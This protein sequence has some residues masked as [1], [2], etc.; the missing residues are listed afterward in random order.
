[1]GNSIYESVVARLSVL[2]PLLSRTQVDI[3][4]ARIGTDP[5]HVTAVQMAQALNRFI[6]P[7]IQE[8][9]HANANLDASNVAQLITD[10]ERRL[11]KISPNLSIITG[12][13]YAGAGGFKDL[14]DRIVPQISDFDRND[15]A[16]RE[17]VVAGRSLVVTSGLQ[18]DDHGNPKRIVSHISDQTLRQKLWSEVSRIHD[19]LETEV[20]RRTAEL[21]ESQESLQRKEEH[22][23]TIV[24]NLPVVIYEKLADGSVS[25]ISHNVDSLWGYKP[26]EFR[27]DSGFLN[28]CIHPEDRAS[29]KMEGASEYR[30]FSRARNSYIWIQDI[31]RSVMESGGVGRR[32]CG[33]MA[34]ITRQKELQEQVFHSQKMETLGTIAAGF[35]HDFLNQLTG[36][37]ANVEMLATKS[38]GAPQ[39][40]DEID[41]ALKAAR[42]CSELVRS[43]LTF[44]SSPSASAVFCSA[45]HVIEECLGLLRYTLPREIHVKVIKNPETWQVRIEERQMVQVLMNL[46]LNGRDAMP[47]GGTLMVET[48]NYVI[49]AKYCSRVR[50]AKP[51]RYVLLSVG[52]TGTGISDDILPRIFEPFF[53]TKE[54]G[55]FYGMGLV[56]VA[57][58]VKAHNGWI[59]VVSHPGDGSN[60][61]VFLPRYVEAPASAP[62]LKREEYAVLVVDESESVRRTSARMLEES[63]CRAILAEDAAEGLRLFQENSSKIGMVILDLSGSGR[64][65][66]QLFQEMRRISSDLR[67]LLTAGHT[68]G[69]ALSNLQAQGARV[70]SKPYTASEFQSVLREMLQ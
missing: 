21:R 12:V 14:L 1:M 65:A 55:I 48:D 54:K 36:I 67:I 9:T 6:L 61:R 28:S 20:A 69:E 70:L 16:L 57:G 34:D 33:V 24:E 50:E 40:R 38:G 13:Q 22:I 4:L 60:F 2:A 19:Q 35:A 63:G 3:G 5:F 64:T 30:F 27:G 41:D 26:G 45:S 59:E 56:S 46:V 51:G 8:V 15:L 23:R 17:V 29:L 53:S 49:D 47:D 52:D 42:R 7:R 66:L 39:Y 37:T 43:M 32:F 58:I 10:P 11:I 25:F 62:N 68:T 18:R 31:S 44:G